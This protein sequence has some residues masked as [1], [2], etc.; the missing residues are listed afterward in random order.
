MAFPNFNILDSGVRANEGPPPS[1]L[2]KSTPV[3]SGQAGW[4]INTNKI[5]PSG[6]GAQSAVWKNTFQAWMEAY[7]KLDTLPETGNSFRIYINLQQDNTA[8]PDGYAL[9]FWHHTGG[10]VGDLSLKRLDNA[11]QTNLATTSMTISAGDQLGIFNEGGTIRSFHNGLQKNAV[12]DSTYYLTGAIGIGIDAGT[13]TRI[14]NFGGGS[15]PPSISPDI[16]LFPKFM[17]RD[18]RVTV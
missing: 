8:A 18:Q 5:A 10:G 4:V 14:S 6:S 12:A 1:A 7:C 3:F 16:R 13:V 2:W 15:G 17:K 9:E 11:A